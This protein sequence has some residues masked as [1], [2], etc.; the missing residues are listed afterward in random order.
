M[1][2]ISAIS[3]TRMDV[4]FRD[5]PVVWSP[6]MVLT[7]LLVD[8]GASDLTHLCHQRLRLHGRTLT[9]SKFRSTSRSIGARSVY[10][11][12]GDAR[13]TLIGRVPWRPSVDGLHQLVNGIGCEMSIMEVCIAAIR[14][15]V[16]AP[17]GWHRLGASAIS[18]NSTEM[19][20]RIYVP[21]VEGV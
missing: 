10:A 14:S 4:R 1:L 16:D 19:Q 12:P 2:G 9:S 5:A 13:V 3:S 6:L 11:S 20:S 7:A 21:N 17:A 8:L 18:H 15:G